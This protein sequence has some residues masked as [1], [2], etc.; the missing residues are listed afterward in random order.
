MKLN[1]FAKDDKLDELVGALAR[2]I[3]GAAKLGAKAIGGTIAALD[4]ASG[5]SADIAP[6]GALRGGASFE[7]KKKDPASAAERNKEIQAAQKDMQDM[8]R[9]KEKEIQEL[10]K[11]MSEL[12]RQ[13]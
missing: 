12:Q 7:P 4:K 3:G 2:G 1:E 9:A 8:I 5:T 11:Q 6:G 13:R 10:R